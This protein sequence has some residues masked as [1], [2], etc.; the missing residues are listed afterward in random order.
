M[1]R[2]QPNGFFNRFLMAL[3]ALFLYAP[4]FILIIFS[5]NE[6]TSSSVWKGFSLH[7]YGQLFHNQIIMR[8]VY[9]TLLVSLLATVIATIAGTFAA[10]GFY[11]MRRR[12][13]DALM[14][15][16]NIPMMNADI[17]T[18]VSLALL[19]VVFFNGWSSFAGWVNSWQSAVVLP[20]KLSM[21]FGTLLIAHVMFN[22]PY[23]ILSVGPKLRQMDRN[24]VDAAQDLGCT[25]MQAF[26]KVIIPEIKPGIV[27]GAL[28]AFTMSI[29]DFIISYFTAGSSTSTLAMTIYGMTK[30]RVSPEINAISTLLFVT[31]LLLLAIVNIREA[32][33]E[34]QPDRRRPA[35]AVPNFTRNSDGKMPVWMRVVAGAVGCGLLAMLIISGRSANARP[36][37]NVCSWGE[38]ID[39]ELI[40]EFE[41]TTGIHVNYQ[42]AESNEALYSLIAMGGADFDVIVPS[43]YM[44]ARLIEED[45]LAELDYD[46]IPNFQLIGEQF[47]HLSYDPE[48]KYTV[49]Y[50]W[51]S[52]GIIYN[53]TMVDEPITSWDA[54][55]D[56]KYAGQV[57][58][59]NNS[60]DALAAALLDLGYDINTTDEQQLTEA[61]QLLKDAK[62]N[63][64][65][66]AFV[67]DQ[68]FQKMEGG[69]AAI[70]MY[71][72]GDY[73]TM[74]D[75][76][77]DLAFVV[78]DEGSN[79]FV[80]AMCV[81][82]NAQHKQEAEAWINFI[83]STEANLANMDFIWYA[84]P[85]AEAL[86]QYPAY[87]EELYEEELDEELY[88][89][90]A[91]G[92]DVLSRC[93]IYENLPQATLQL[94]ND[95]WNQLGI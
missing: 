90:M 24:L 59:I 41:E 55:F 36:V 49:P 53:E 10:I 17:V 48:N 44:I 88:E 11:A 87:Y 86:E 91:P 69:N 51:G 23:V 95:L 22:I 66:Q 7:W 28:T 8:S 26:W 9:I 4:I 25:W 57:L 43:D 92:E 60:R 16:N 46:N 38:Y 52:L 70:A 83:A 13:R 76:N 73:L 27:S 39:E 54:M 80:D 32:S 64:V 62:D 67:M 5:F 72:A 30:K 42:T 21:G 34:R 40:T 2:Q 74:L 47:T 15:V 71:Y 20:E 1:K 18:G 61:F 37:V 12:R 63:G 75:N 89:I 33:M 94:Y 29:D 77:E 19:F 3:V 6:G 56:P 68:V 93:E 79:W 85:N 50:T 45:R 58:M 14:A 81:L 35:A 31:V 65:Y 84:S 82:K 78:P